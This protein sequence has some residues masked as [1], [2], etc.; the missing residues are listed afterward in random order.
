MRT[1]ISIC[2]SPSEFEV[3]HDIYTWDALAW[4]LYKNEQ[5]QEAAT[6][7]K[8]AL[9][10]DTNDALLYFHAGTIYESLSLHETAQDLLQRAVALN[11]RFHVLYADAARA[12]LQKLSRNSVTEKS[13]GTVDAHP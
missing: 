1:T 11:P 2:A 12:T 9:R 5:S 3:R 4:A 7:M 8:E 10:L 6:T 13:R